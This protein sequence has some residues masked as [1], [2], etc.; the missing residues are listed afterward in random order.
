MLE[1]VI[2][3]ETCDFLLQMLS[4]ILC[5]IFV[6]VYVPKV[7][8]FVNVPGSTVLN[9]FQACSFREQVS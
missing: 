4:V 5:A 1:T 7:L 3:L 6:L 9:H 8:C 2:M